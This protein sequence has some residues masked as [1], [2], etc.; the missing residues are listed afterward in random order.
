[1]GR[2]ATTRGV[3][4]TKLHVG[5]VDDPLEQEADQVAERV[6]RMPDPTAGAGA[7]ELPMTAAGARLS[8]RCAACKGDEEEKGAE[9]QR[10]AAP[11]APT[12]SA[13]APPIVE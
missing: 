12:G 13:E 7:P 2:L 6:L 10:R 11:G 4:Q 5:S 3:L 9:V 8:R 1:M